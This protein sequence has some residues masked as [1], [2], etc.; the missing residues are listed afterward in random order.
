MRAYKQSEATP[1]QITL[2]SIRSIPVQINVIL[3]TYIVW[4]FSVLLVRKRTSVSYIHY[5]R[6]FPKKLA[7]LLLL[8]LI[9][10]CYSHQLQSSSVCEQMIRRFLTRLSMNRIILNRLASSIRHTI[11][12]IDKDLQLGAARASLMRKPIQRCTKV[13]SSKFDT[14]SIKNV[15]SMIDNHALVVIKSTVNLAI[16]IQ[17]PQLILWLALKV[18][19]SKLKGRKVVIDMRGSDTPILVLTNAGNQKAIRFL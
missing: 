9:Q 5:I 1:K 12:V 14:N 11:R 15:S 18:A 16:G 7:V 19:R 4:L 6:Q 17:T 2:L 10:I 3:V 13:T 8:L